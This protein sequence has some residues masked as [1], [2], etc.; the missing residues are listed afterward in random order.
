MSCKAFSS[1]YK[2]F[3]IFFF[4]QME[5]HVQFMGEVSVNSHCLES[6]F[7][8]YTWSTPPPPLP[9]TSSQKYAHQ[10][11]SRFSYC[12]SFSHG[13]MRILPIFYRLPKSP[14]RLSAILGKFYIADWIRVNSYTPYQQKYKTKIEC[15]NPD[16]SDLMSNS[17]CFQCMR[18]QHYNW[19]D[20]IWSYKKG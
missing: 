20:V 13:Q 3:K 6:I 8:H 17:A 18:T 16:R 15:Q 7:T 14:I 5:K 19:L 9:R 10:G 2:F 4:I 1:F 11:A 12:Q